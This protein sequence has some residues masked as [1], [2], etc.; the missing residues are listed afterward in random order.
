MET[1]LPKPEHTEA[2]HPSDRPNDGGGVAAPVATPP[3]RIP[4]W[5]GTVV[6]D[7]APVRSREEA[8][9]R[10]R[11]IAN[12]A[13]AAIGLVAC[14]PILLLIAALV[15]LTTPGPVLY[16][17]MRVGADRRQRTGPTADSRPSFDPGGR[18]FEL[19]KFRTM[20][21]GSDG[22]GQVWA[23]PDDPRV[24]PIGRVLRAYRLDELPQLINVLKGEMN[25]VGPR[26]EQPEIAAKLSRR[27]DR[28]PERQ[29]VRPGITGLAQVNHHYDRTI[30]DVK[31]K[32]RFDLEYLA[33]RSVIEDLKIMLRTIPV[34]L[35]CRGAW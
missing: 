3:Y 20:Y 22:D 1:T 21:V 6:H 19:Y 12:V 5:T 27:I 34:M 23:R 7:D 24:T 31:T 13:V 8:C 15:K 35:R 33:R 17:Q 29:T 18:P 32:L 9:E 25:V 16:R 2:A 30:D 4:A 10:R 26:P 28:Y 14:A 11:R